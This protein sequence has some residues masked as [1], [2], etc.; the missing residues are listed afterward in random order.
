MAQPQ[1]ELNEWHSKSAAASGTDQETYRDVATYTHTL[2][3][4]GKA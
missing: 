3:Q 4:A 1:P 2:T